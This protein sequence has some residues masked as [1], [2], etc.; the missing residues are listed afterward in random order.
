M[1]RSF[2]PP[3][4]LNGHPHRKQ[5]FLSYAR[6]SMSFFI[7]CIENQRDLF[8][9]GSDRTPD[10]ARQKDR[11]RI[12]AFTALRIW[13]LRVRRAGKNRSTFGITRQT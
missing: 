10:C 8:I 2:S 12:T 4:A 7:P 11:H 1:T 6:G 13:A 9:I 5:S 3:A